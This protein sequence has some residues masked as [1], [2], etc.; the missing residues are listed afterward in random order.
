MVDVDLDFLPGDDELAATVRVDRHRHLD[1]AV[2][3]DVVG[4]VGAMPRWSSSETQ[5]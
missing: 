2:P 1:V 3:D 4:D 5:V